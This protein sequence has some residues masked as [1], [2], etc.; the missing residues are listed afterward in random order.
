MDRG[1]GD[2]RQERL[3]DE[4]VVGVD[5][6]D[7]ELAAPLLL[8]RLGREYAAEAAA[9]HQHLLL[10]HGHLSACKSHICHGHTYAN[11][12]LRQVVVSEAELLCGQPDT[13]AR[14]LI[15]LRSEERR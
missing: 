5:E 8:E 13:R 9:D 14:P 2:L 7:L 4:I 12:A 6:L 15:S 3:E 1:G 10:S 11:A